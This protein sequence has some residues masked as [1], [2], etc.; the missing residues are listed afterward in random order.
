MPSQHKKCFDVK[1]AHQNKDGCSKCGDSTQV[2]GF[3]C[4]AKKFQ[5]KACHK[6]GHFTS[7]CY[8]KKQAPFKSRKPKAHQLQEWAVYAKESAIYSQS[9]DDSSSQD[10]FCLQVKVKHTQ[11]NLQR[12]PRPTRL[13]TNLAYR[14]KSHHTRDLYLRARLHTCADV[15]VMPASMYR[16]IFKDSEIKKLALSSLE[17]GTYTTDTVK[18]V[19]PCTFYLVCQDTKN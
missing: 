17:I 3:Q 18:I 15:N 12:I 9:E 8:Q 13:I 10:S 19:G 7:L 5:F 11:P 1:N 4:P 16:L 14:E 6:F 2:E